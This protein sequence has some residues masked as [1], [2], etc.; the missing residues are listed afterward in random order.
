MPRISRKRALK[1]MLRK[2]V[3]LFSLI[4]TMGGVDSDDDEW[5]E[6]LILK[7]EALD[8]ERFAY[9]RKRY[10]RKEKKREHLNLWKAL[11]LNNDDYMPESDFRHEFR[12]TKDEF[13]LLHDLIK[14]HPVFNQ[15]GRGRR[16][17]GCSEFKLLVLLKYLGHFGN[18]NTPKSV[19]DFFGIGVGTFYR[20]V[21]DAMVAVLSFKEEVIKWPG[22][23]ERKEIAAVFEQVSGLPHCVGLCDGTGFPLE[24]KPLVDHDSFYSRKCQYAI[25][26]LIICDHKGRIRHF[27]VGWR[28]TV[29]DN[30]VWRNCVLV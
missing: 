22:L 14:T 10:K 30:R 1:R 29:D 9:R 25:H 5:M 12:M 27:V 23:A 18:S 26:A 7:L 28:G 2:E 6:E 17:K 3:Q 19:A 20:Y 16:G 13:F 4:G 21:H 24:V 15:K 8:K 11:D